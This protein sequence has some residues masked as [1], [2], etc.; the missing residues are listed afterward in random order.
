[1]PG[2]NLR[3]IRGRDPL[4]EVARLIAQADPYSE[5]ASGDAYQMNERYSQV[6]ERHMASPP[7]APSC[8]HTAQERRYESESAGSRYFPRPRRKSTIINAMKR[9]CLCLGTS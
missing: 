1:M 7:S 4:A 9:L 8:S 3:S 5:R 2:N 6:G